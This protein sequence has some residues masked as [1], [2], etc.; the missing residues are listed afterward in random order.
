MRSNGRPFSEWR[1]LSARE[2]IRQAYEI[3]R[4]ADDPALFISL[5]DEA[6]ALAEAEALD[7]A[8]RD[9]KPL[10]GLPF[11]AK[12]NID[13]AGMATTAACPDFSYMAEASAFVVA[14]LEA[15]GAICIGKTNLDQF[16]T[17]LVGVR[18]PY[19]VPK[20]ALDPAL[21]PGG[22]SSGSAVAVA[23]GMVAF[24]LGTDTAG[25]GRIPAGMNGI[26]GLKPSLG[27]LSATG[28]VP[29]CRTL[30]TISIFAAS[31]NDAAEA[32]AAAQG[33]DAADFLSREL[34]AAGVA[35]LPPHFTVGVPL[36]GQRQFF[37][38]VKSQAAFEKDLETLATLGAIIREID[39]EPLHAVA[40]LLYEGPWVAERYHAIREIIETRPEIL[41][42][43]TRQIIG[44]AAKISAVDTFDAIYKLAAM[45]R[46]VAPILAGLDCLAVPTLPAVYTVA[47][48]EADPVRLNS[49]LGTYTNFVNLL[50]LAAISVPVGE[51]SDGLPSS[52]T[53]IGKAG[54]DARLAG[55]AAAL[56]AGA[57]PASEATVP[58]GSV[59]LAVVGAHLSGM[60]LNHELTSRDA[61]FLRALSTAPDYR[62]Y[63]L[64]GT[65]PPK[66][67]LLRVDE[68][69]GRKDRRRIVGDVAGSLRELRRGDPLASR[70]RHAGAGRRYVGER[71]PG[72]GG[73]GEQRPRHLFLRILAQFHGRSVLSVAGKFVPGLLDEADM[74]AHG[75][76]RRLAVSLQDRLDDRRVFGVGGL[77]APELA[78]L[79]APERLQANAGIERDFGEIGVP[80][81]VV[82]G[83]VKG[84]VGLGI[85]RGI[86]LAHQ[87]GHI[88]VKLFERA[89][90]HRRHRQ[91]AEAGAQRLQIAHYGEHAGKRALVRLGDDRL[92]V[93][94]LL[95]QAGRGEDTQRL[96]HGRPRDAEIG[97]ELAFVERRPRLEVSR[98]DP[99]CD[100]EPY[101]L[102]GSRRVFHGCV[103]GPKDT[104]QAGS[105]MIETCAATTRH[106]SGMR[107]Q[108]CI[109]RPTLP[110]ALSR[111]NSVDAVA[112]SVP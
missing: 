30:D 19:G 108:V 58:D 70:Y 10:F 9:G 82:D 89:A 35:A 111:R 37:G 29:A 40:R 102:H 71:L 32:A 64:D 75:G 21:I 34:P 110:L 81:A 5:K 95:D 27:M 112:K 78:E 26:V 17:G 99:A 33:Y 49:N 91:R 98:N 38:D 6:A 43:V 42:P 107:T 14:R 18:S 103:H 44:G 88:G 47:Q 72:R 11:A 7:K 15:A 63:A 46:Q 28:M 96:A 24:S 16:A 104:I 105:S 56:E 65:V 62:L 93:G 83:V 1:I 79:G 109:W 100:F 57:R 87:F 45:K 54:S 41:H 2:A 73:R 22:S 3:I 4:E 23:R 20:N 31:V 25:S 36:P 12:D 74:I 52:L 55:Y 51:R 68:G 60:P 61:T 39:F 90:L 94:A 97:G 59:T 69:A 76:L 50:D 8:G 85:G 53:L 86:S 80:G 106:P 92:A 101:G 67:G 13:A 48:V 66:P 77:Q 84:L